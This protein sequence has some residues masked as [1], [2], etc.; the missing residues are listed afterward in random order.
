MRSV[1]HGGAGRIVLKADEENSHLL[2]PS[3]PRNSR[4]AIGVRSFSVLYDRIRNRSAR[5]VLPVLEEFP[6]C[7][8][9]VANV[10]GSLRRIA[11]QSLVVDSF[12]P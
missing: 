11:A 1:L 5:G 4:P 8:L 6:L 10:H 9:L 2:Y 12:L 3:G 7:R